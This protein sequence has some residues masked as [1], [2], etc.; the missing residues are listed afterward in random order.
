MRKLL[1]KF[2][3]LLASPS[4]WARLIGSVLLIAL[5]FIYVISGGPHHFDAEGHWVRG[6]FEDA[7]SGQDSYYLKLFK[8]RHGASHE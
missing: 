8:M 6:W 3:S 7:G 2:Q 1:F 5:L 4:G